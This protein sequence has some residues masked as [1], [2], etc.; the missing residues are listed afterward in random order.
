[1]IFNHF[2][3]SKKNLLKIIESYG[4]II[5]KYNKLKSYHK[6]TEKIPFI[7]YKKTFNNFKRLYLL[8]IYIYIAKIKYIF[9]NN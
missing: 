1:M 4:I 2:T 6:I 5:I 3:G 7:F 8:Y 9:E